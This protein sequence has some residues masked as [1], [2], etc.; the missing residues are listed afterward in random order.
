MFE[1]EEQPESLESSEVTLTLIYDDYGEFTI[2]LTT[3]VDVVCSVT[4]LTLDFELAIHHNIF[5]RD[6]FVL[7]DFLTE[8]S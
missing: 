5:E 7:I 4:N 6:T 2:D 1:I 3:H 8:P